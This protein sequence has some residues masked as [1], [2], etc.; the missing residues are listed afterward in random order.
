MFL[1]HSRSQDARRF[2][3]TAGRP[4]LYWD[5][6]PVNDV[7]MGFELHV[8]PYLGR[9]P[10]LATASRGIVA[11]PMELFEASRIP[12]ATIA[13]FLRDPEPLF[14]A[15]RLT[16]EEADMV[17]RRDWQA[18]IHYGVIFFMLEKLGAVV[19]ASNLH[20]YAAM[21]GQTL[22]EFQKTRNAQVTYGVGGNDPAKNAFDQ[23]KA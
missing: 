19:G 22:D 14:A 10:R 2:E 23:P 3:R 17:R 13:D 6:Y 16:E 9:D 15:A 18:M 12:L 20:I 11:N 8:G 1:K 4:P 7:A 5:N 21:R